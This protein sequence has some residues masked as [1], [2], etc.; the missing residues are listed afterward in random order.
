MSRDST[1][2]QPREM[3]RKVILFELNEVP[4][5]V[6]DDHTTHSPDGVMAATLRRCRQYVTVAPDV[7]HLSPWTTWPSVHR[8]VPDHVH[9]IG[10]L[11]QGRDAVDK[12]YPPVW[13]LLHDHGA[14][15]GV[16][17]SL[18]SYPPPADMSSYAFYLPDAFAEDDRAHPRV[19]SRFQA[20]NLTM[21]RLSARNVDPSISWSQA[22]RV[23]TSSR[24]LGIRP[25]T[26]LT[27]AAQLAAE[28]REPR[29]RSR[30]RTLQAAL[31]F[32]VFMTQLERTAPDFSTFFSNHVASSLHRYWAATYPEDY[33]DL[34]L[35]RDWLESYREE[36]PWAMRAAERML[37]RLVAFADAHPEYQVW[38]ASSM[39]QRA[40][41]AQSVETA[42]YLVDLAA[43]MH[44]LGMPDGSWQP[45]PAMLPQTNVTVIDALAGSFERRLSEL[46]LVDKPLTYR[47][48]DGGFFAM[49]FG[50]ANMHSR[51]TPVRYQGERHA[52]AAFGMKAVEIED[53]SGTTAYHVPEGVLFIYDPQRSA[54]LAT[55]RTVAGTA[56]GRPQISTLEIAPALLH[57]F[58]VPRPEYMAPLSAAG[59]AES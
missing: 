39:G 15:V 24:G 9:L 5:R 26:Y 35:D 51:P 56:A 4:W 6:V 47:R 44:R 43:F 42:V 13:R 16:C 32:D 1:W 33:R 50:H 28:L 22:V 59:P 29:R 21:T 20:F 25:T 7:G 12:T 41:L 18:H 17:C 54:E 55:S 38:T 3:H 40:T 37:A 49:D 52:L 48:G 10:D 53:R 19:L 14:T 57:A 27:I 34:D 58:G 23:L 2:Q 8:G 11:G 31:A 36:I 45:R 46:R 30:R